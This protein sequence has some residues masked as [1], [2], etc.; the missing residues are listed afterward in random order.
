MRKILLLGGTKEA[1]LLAERI[2]AGDTIQVVYSLA[3]RTREPLLPTCL[4]RYGGFGGVQGLVTYLQEQQINMV[5]DATHAFAQIM[6]KHA[7]LACQEMHIPYLAFVSEAWS[8]MPDDLWYDAPTVAQSVDI[9]EKL[10]TRVFLAIGRQ[11][12]AA[13]ASLPHKWFL[14]RSIEMPAEPLPPQHVVVLQRGP[15]AFDDELQLLQRYKIDTIVTKNSGGSAAYAKI[16]AARALRLP[17]IVI[18]RP[19]RPAAKEFMNAD[20]LLTHIFT[21]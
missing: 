8:A 21:R 13:F 20:D 1:R 5:V 9:V 16:E 19:P 14:I 10:G 18:T 3:G 4:I 2:S 6:R 12:L 11:E 7:A 15:F 17:V